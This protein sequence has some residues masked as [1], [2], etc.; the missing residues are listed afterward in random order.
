MK[1]AISLVI[2]LHIFVFVVIVSCNKEDEPTP[3]PDIILNG[4]TTLEIYD[5]TLI[6]NGIELQE[7]LNGYWTIIEKTDFAVL[8]DS[9]DPQCV[10]I[11]KPRGE[12]KLRWTVENGKE[13]KTVDITIKM[14][15][16]LPESILTDG[17]TNFELYDTLFVLNGIELQDGLKGTWEIINN[18][19]LCLLSDSLD[20]NCQF[21]GKLLGEYKLRWTVENGK[22]NKYEEIN[23]KIIGFTDSRDNEKYLVIRMGNQIWMAE[24]LKT[25]TY[26][27][28]DLIND[29]TDVGDYSGEFEPKYWFA[30]NDNLANIDTYGRLYTWYATTDPRNIAPE[31]WH[32]PTNSEW[33]KLQ[34]YMGMNASDTILICDENNYIGGKLKQTGTD[35]WLS[36]N[37][38]ATN[39]FSFNALPAGYRRRFY[40]NFEYIGDYACFWTSN[41]N[42][43]DDSYAWYRH[44]YSQKASIC[45]TYNMKSYGFSV[46]CV[47]D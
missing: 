35:V 20:P 42:D 44:L 5:T 7:G 32:V 21:A 6:L 1:N 40:K 13:E 28:G 41:Q 38:G 29:G 4:E 26:Q 10:F 16:S 25:T 23:I 45:C 18:T 15:T 37:V 43:G 9:L 39:E 22:D 3:I 17:N 12:Y 14:F 46:R 31:G 24:N 8:R 19:D 33:N 30:Y 11:G 47:K 27:N 2:A 36:P 34:V